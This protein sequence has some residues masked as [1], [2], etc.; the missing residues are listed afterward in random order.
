MHDQQCEIKSSIAFVPP[1][2]NCI[3]L[4]E[5]SSIK[6]CTQPSQ[7]CSNSLH[8]LFKK[9]MLKYHGNNHEHSKLQKKKKS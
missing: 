4:F 6:S 2:S 9:D 7:I 3:T 8:R 5:L 1:K